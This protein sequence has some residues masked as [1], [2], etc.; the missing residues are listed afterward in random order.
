MILFHVKTVTF[1]TQNIDCV[2]LDCYHLFIA[3]R[4]IVSSVTASS[5]LTIDIGT[6][7]LLSLKQTRKQCLTMF[8]CWK[9]EYNTLKVQYSEKP[10]LLLARILHT[11]QCPKYTQS[12]QWKQERIF[13]LWYFQW[14]LNSQLCFYPGTIGEDKVLSEIF[15]ISRCTVW[16]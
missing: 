4:R 16:G 11:W 5:S 2:G 12:A 7:I 14:W 9:G 3:G 8:E 13:L 10:R 15:I 6:I 1:V